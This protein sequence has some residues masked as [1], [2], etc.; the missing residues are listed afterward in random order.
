M[1][2]TYAFTTV[3]TCD[4]ND[5]LHTV[6]PAPPGRACQVQAVLDA[7][8]SSSLK[9]EDEGTE[10]DEKRTYRT[11]YMFSATMPPAVERLARKYLR[12]SVWKKGREGVPQHCIT[13]ARSRHKWH[14]PPQERYSAD[15]DCS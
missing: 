13:H 1:Y 4:P 15:R 6:P 2:L 9:P 5:T 14:H 8:P 12:R 11:T 10:L 3:R 7:M